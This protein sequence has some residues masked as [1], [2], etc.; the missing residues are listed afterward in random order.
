MAVDKHIRFQRAFWVFA[1]IFVGTAIRLFKHYHCKVTKPKSKVFLALYNHTDDLDPFYL[2]IGLFRHMRYVASSVILEGFIGRI[3][4][5]LVGPIP[6][7]KA[8]SADDTVELMLENMK[9]GISIALSAE[10]NRSWDGETMF[11]SPRTAEV[12]KRSGAALVTFRIRGGYL[13]T[14]RFA[15]YARK[16]PVFGEMVR[17]YSPEELSHMSV[18]EIEDAIAKDLYVNAYQDQKDPPPIIKDYLK[19]RKMVSYKGKAKAENIE[20]ILYICP[21]CHGIGTL[22]SHNDGFSCTCGLSGKIN[23]YGF[24]EG[25]VPF[26][27]TVDWNRW[28]KTYLKEQPAVL[29]KSTEVIFTDNRAELYITKMNKREQTAKNAEVFFYPD[30]IVIKDDNETHTFMLNEITRFAAFRSQKVYFTCKDEYCELIFDHI[31]SGM[32]YEAFWRV[33]TGRPYL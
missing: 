33:L 9:A 4:S 32:K 2:A 31:V 21:V 16:G 15:A 29:A 6:R 17:E 22:S 24:L 7:K 25:N 28:Q 30:R 26:D 13:H 8:A 19:G 20:S 23:D 5:F 11:I 1:Q 14:P 10:G 27:N 3:I 18:Q 12:A